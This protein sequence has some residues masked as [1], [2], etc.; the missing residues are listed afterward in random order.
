M[1]PPTPILACLF[2]M[3]GLLLDSEDLYTLCTNILLAE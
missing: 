1:T 3:D 2:D